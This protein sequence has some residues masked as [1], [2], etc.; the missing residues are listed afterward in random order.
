MKIG[1]FGGSFDPV[2]L[3][4]LLVARAA[5][6]ELGLARLIFIPAAQ[7]PST[8]KPNVAPAT[9][10][11]RLQLLRLALAGETACE[12]DDFEIRRGG[13]SYTIATLRHYAGKTSGAA[14]FYLIGSDQAALLPEYMF[15]QVRRENSAKLALDAMEKRVL[16]SRS[17]VLLGR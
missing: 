17:I 5:L 8:F 6:E 2:H 4:Y 14:L 11:V 12:I 15:R 13:L 9:A 16:L 1:L 3:G 7:S 10:L